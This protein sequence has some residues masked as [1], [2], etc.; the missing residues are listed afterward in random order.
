[1][2]PRDVGRIVG[3]IRSHDFCVSCESVMDTKR[4]GKL[5]LRKSVVC[6]CDNE[7]DDGQGRK[8]AWK[9]L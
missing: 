7:E 2:V 4:R 6:V 1:M 8:K 9:G 5:C 3:E